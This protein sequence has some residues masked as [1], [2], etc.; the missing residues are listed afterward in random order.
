MP[1]ERAGDG[2]IGSPIHVTWSTAAP[3]PGLVFDAQYL[4]PGSERG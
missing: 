4:P 3:A 1:V 2:T